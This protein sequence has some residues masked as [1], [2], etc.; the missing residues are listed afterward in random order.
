MEN[1]TALLLTN[2]AAVSGNISG[3]DFMKAQN[4]FNEPMVIFCN[5]HTQE[6]YEHFRIV[7]EDMDDLERMY[8]EKVFY[9]SSIPEDEVKRYGGA[10]FV[11]VNADYYKKERTAVTVRSS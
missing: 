2:T 11:G 7:A 4:E 5:L 6:S 8:K 9:T 3:D 1:V 10:I